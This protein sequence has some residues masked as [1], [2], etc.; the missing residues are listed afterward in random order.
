MMWILSLLPTTVADFIIIAMILIGFAGVLIGLFFN[1]IPVISKY[2]IPIKILGIALLVLGIYLKGSSDTEKEWK[3]KLKDAEH[4][5]VI[6][7]QKAK[8]AN[9]KIEYV[10]V[11]RVKKVKDVQVVIQERIKEI[12]PEIDAACTLTPSAIDV[13]NAAAKNV[14]P[15]ATK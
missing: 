10:F 6:A 11:D 15:G 2:S 9:A 14:K 13:L 1:N 12:A 3:A 7:E 4:K 8:E 5:A